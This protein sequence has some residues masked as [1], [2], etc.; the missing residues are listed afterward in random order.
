MKTS[1]F[2]SLVVCGLYSCHKQ[3]DSVLDGSGAVVKLPHLWKTS[4]SDNGELTQVVVKG[5]AVYDDGKVIVG[6]N[7]NTQRSLLIL[8]QNQ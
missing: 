5:T 8:I 2:L 3:E 7:K 6:G 1:I 4:I